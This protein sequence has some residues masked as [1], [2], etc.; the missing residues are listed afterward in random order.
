MRN[1]CVSRREI[2]DAWAE[3]EWDETTS[4]CWEDKVDKVRESFLSEVSASLRR[5]SRAW[6]R[7]ERDSDMRETASLSGWIL[8]LEI[9]WEIKVEGGSSRSIFG[10]GGRE[11]N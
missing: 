3:E 4:L 5:R 11:G 9:V 2:S 8:K 1:F 6:L 7:V 10:R